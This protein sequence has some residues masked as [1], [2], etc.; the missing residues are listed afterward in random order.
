MEVG[1]QCLYPCHQLVRCAVFTLSQFFLLLRMRFDAVVLLLLVDVVFG[2]AIIWGK[3]RPVGKGKVSVFGATGGL[4]QWSCHY[5]LK[6]K[7][8]VYAIT[9][10]K[11]AVL[12]ALSSGSCSQFELLRGC[13]LV[14]ANARVLDEALIESVRGAKS[15]IISLGTTA[16]PTKKWEGGN[17]PKAACV[18][19]GRSFLQTNTVL[20]SYNNSLQFNC[21]C[22]HL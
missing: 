3:L 19:T 13:K 20:H 16:F 11:F 5:L 12:E 6:G 1:A 2:I 10:D 8:D 15:V 7:H 18:D 4:G 17:R 21:S 9:R 22:K 14:E